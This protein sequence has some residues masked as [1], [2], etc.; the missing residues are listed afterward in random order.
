MAQRTFSFQQESI[1]KEES[2]KA[3]G[4]ATLQLEQAR[5]Q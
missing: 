3:L 2:T 5:L 1:D 4:E